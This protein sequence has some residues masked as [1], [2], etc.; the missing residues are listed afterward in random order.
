[1]TDLRRH[2]ATCLAALERFGRVS[3]FARMPALGN[4]EDLAS[5]TDAAAF[6]EALDR[7]NGKPVPCLPP[8]INPRRWKERHT[9]ARW[10]TARAIRSGT[11]LHLP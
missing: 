8:A 4:W 11:V 1:M 9:L 10:L 7:L 6:T 3:E 5:R 2:I